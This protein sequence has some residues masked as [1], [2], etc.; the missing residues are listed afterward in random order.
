MHVSRP[1]RAR[2]NGGA[3]RVTSE[4]IPA[5][6]TILVVDASAFGREMLASLLESQGYHI[7]VC[8]PAQLIPKLNDAKPDLMI[9]DPGA[10]EPSGFALLE[11]VRRDV[12]WKDLPIV[13]VT[14]LSNKGAVL[15]AASNG[16]RD[17][18]LKSRFTLA[19]LL[20]RVRK[21]ATPQGRAPERAAEKAVPQAASVRAA[22]VPSASPDEE[23]ELIRQA[24]EARGIAILT[25]GQMLQRIDRAKLKTLPGAIADLIGLVSSPRGSVFDVAQALK[26][27]PVLCMRVLRVANSAAFAS[28]RART[29]SVED[30]VKSI[31]VAG[32]RNL[33][34]GVGIFETFAT[35][36][37]GDVATGIIRC[38]QHS[39]AVASLME[40]LTPDSDE[41]PNGTAYIVGLCHDLADIILRQYFFEEY[42]SVLTL[43]TETRRPQREV[44]RV[45]F[46]L[47]RDELVTILLARLGLP[48]VITAPIQEFFERAEHPKQRGSGSVLGRTLRMANVY[49]HGLMLAQS[50]EEPV[51]PLSKAEC[52]TTLGHHVPPLDD[53]ELR[54]GAITT[55][56]VLAGMM[57]SNSN[58][59]F[60]P[61]IPSRPLRLAYVR[62]EEY[63]Q[64]DPLH[65]LLK[66]AAER[67]ELMPRFPYQPQE[68]QEMDAM[69][70]AASRSAD[71]TQIQ[72]DI[73][74]M[75]KL[76][77]SWP[78]RI[79]YLAGGRPGNIA[80][81][82]ETVTIAR[83]PITIADL[84][85]YLAG[86]QTSLV[87][88]A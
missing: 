33:V 23:R 77:A 65:T 57:S 53:S 9:L 52:I 10:N 45:L 88:A 84:G 13:A 51:L 38:W 21:Y 76:S 8:T 85:A 31:G 22:Q 60:E 30:A 47:P 28:E 79:L 67:V 75:T 59:Q 71:A 35:N 19:E 18:I 81:L 25:K 82:P 80:G 6:S 74:R 17:Y 58:K 66:L 61:F 83:L 49:A 15:Q 50:A 27:D 36:E 70:V 16:V 55:A 32:V 78:G 40:K 69:V 41:A 43:A 62:N 11:S 3:A 37:E 12:R 4:G 42:S 20:I 26:R 1:K 24:A 46:G 68:I 2:Q 29:T 87:Q 5:M 44:E 54:S 48:A 14:E 39:L 34:M 73:E 64:L 86:C 72:N 63:A 56:A 7:V